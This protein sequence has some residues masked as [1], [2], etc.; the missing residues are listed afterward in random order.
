ML[1][2]TDGSGECKEEVAVVQR[3]QHRGVLMTAKNLEKIPVVYVR[4]LGRD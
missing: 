4:C 1:I 2:V 3:G